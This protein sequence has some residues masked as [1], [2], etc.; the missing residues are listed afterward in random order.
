MSALC[1]CQVS[2]VV[3]RRV[4][5][6]RLVDHPYLDICKRVRKVGIQ[7]SHSCV[8]WRTMKVW[9]CLCLDIFSFHSVLMKA[10]ERRCGSYW[11][12][13]RIVLPCTGEGPITGRHHRKRFVEELSSWKARPV[14]HFFLFSF[15]FLQFQLTHGL[16]IQLL[17]V[18]VYYCK[19]CN[20]DV[21]PTISLF[22]IE[23]WGGEQKDQKVCKSS[24]CKAVHRY[25]LTF[26]TLIRF[27]CKR[28]EI[29]SICFLRNGRQKTM[30]HSTLKWGLRRKLKYYEYTTNCHLI[31]IYC[32]SWPSRS[33]KIQDQ[34][35]EGL[36]QKQEAATPQ[37]LSVLFTAAKRGSSL[38]RRLVFQ[39]LRGTYSC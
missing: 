9:W 32:F 20:V 22:F 31:F 10:W 21:D 34:N 28:F 14:L 24:K 3:V 4:R 5:S 29:F 13:I 12:A 23:K 7:D 30:I 36:W 8:E 37:T 33:S 1:D 26:I 18:C 15:C 6:V 2:L 39:G 16:L 27:W 19:Q 38:T 35:N 25:L 11:F 17:G